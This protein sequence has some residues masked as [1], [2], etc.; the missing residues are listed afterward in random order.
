MLFCCV[1]LE[2]C[3]NLWAAKL[4]ADQTGLSAA[5]AATGLTAFTAGLAAGR[6]AGARLALRM[7]PTTL[8]VGALALTAAGWAV[9]WLS[10]EPVLS[11]AG[12]AVSGLGVSLHFPHG[13]V[14]GAGGLRRASAT[15]RRPWPP[16]SP[17]SRWGRARSCWARWPTAFGTHQAFLHGSRPDRAGHRRDPGRLQVT[18]RTRGPARGRS[19][20]RGGDRRSRVPAARTPDL[21][22][23]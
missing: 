23:A 22:A 8:F 20:F 1:A 10:E 15:K 13:A 4:V 17:A 18:C 5:M 19:P 6:F 12:L 2:F 14:A 7:A 16:S 21:P 11:Y 9:F 3:F